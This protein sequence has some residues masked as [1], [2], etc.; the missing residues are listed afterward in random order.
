MRKEVITGRWGILMVALLVV[1]M[2]ASAAWSWFGSGKQKAADDGMMP[3]FTLSSALDGPNFNSET[4]KGNVLL[5][6]FWA[7]WCGPCVEEYPDLMRLQKTFA[8]KGFSVIGI[9]TDQSKSS[10]VKFI[11]KAGHNYPMVMT[12]SAVTRSFGAGIGLPVSFLVDRKGKI[13]KRYYGPRSFEQF[14]KD[15]EGL[16]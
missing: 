2:Q 10:V 1:L 16:L 13:A 7:T 4:L 12:T 3:Q 14:S 15:I 5:I 11:E 9:S 6:N 8:A